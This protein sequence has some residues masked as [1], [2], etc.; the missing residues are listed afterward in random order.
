VPETDANRLPYTVEPSRY[1]ITLT[2][3]LDAGSFTGEERVHVRVHEQ[4]AEMVLNAADLEI[5]E[6]RLWAEDGTLREGRVTLHHADERVV[7]TLD[8]PA[9]PGATPS[10]SAS[11]GC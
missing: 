11:P 4:S 6:A 9:P 8:Q 2:P 5:H 3:D 1:E 10:T 7:I